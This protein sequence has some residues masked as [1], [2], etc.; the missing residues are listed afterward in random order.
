MGALSTVPV[1]AIRVVNGVP[2]VSLRALIRATG[3]RPFFIRG[4]T[5]SLEAAERYMQDA[6]PVRVRSKA[7]P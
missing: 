6:K 3:A 7:R 5:L 4:A 1:A 2:L